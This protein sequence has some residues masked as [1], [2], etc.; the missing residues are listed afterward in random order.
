MGIRNM[1]GKW[2][3]RFR[4]QGQDVCVLTALAATERNRKKAEQAEA[5]HRQAI[6]EGRWGFRPLKPRAFIEAVK[7][8]VDWCKIEYGGKPETWRRIA[9]SMTSCS[10]F[11]GK[12]MVSMIH[13]GDVE[14]YKVWRLSPRQETIDG[15]KVTITPVQSVTVKHDLDNLSVFFKW[16]VKADFARHNPLKEVGRPSDV[17]AVRQRIL[18]DKEEKLYFAHVKGNLAKVARLI[19]LQG[20]RP[21]EVMRIRKQDVDI[22]KGTL[23]IEHGKT[24]SA[25]RVLKL[26]QESRSILAGQL[27]THGPWIFPS[28]TKRGSHIT[29][30]NCPHDRALAWL[31]PCQQCGKL[32]AQHP[33]EKCARWIEPL[34]PLLFV[35]YDLRH[36]FATRMVE[37]GVDLVALKQIL[38]HSDIRVTMRYVHPT[39]AH[40]DAAMAIYDKL[41]EDRRKMETVQ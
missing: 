11:F 21:E 25:R 32:E 5:A 4:V 27:G 20:M 13:P 30:L 7:E 17:G 12:Q 16:A 22:E 14:R 1:R 9:T 39:Q 38:G 18:T 15:K 36:T 23:R 34:T 37:A 10:A 2:Q 3:Y 35:L 19:L 24:R 6:L 8:F 31:N 40:Q 33:A 41:N 26:T 28:P 29:K